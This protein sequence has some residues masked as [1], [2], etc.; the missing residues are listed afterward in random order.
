MQFERIFEITYSFIDS[1]SLSHS[2]SSGLEELR[3][4]FRV[5]RESPNS[6]HTYIQILETKLEEQTEV[7]GVALLHQLNK[8]PPM[9]LLRGGE[10]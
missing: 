3:I 10:D 2:M 4:L 6:H 5:L 1:L 8:L 7:D 9:I